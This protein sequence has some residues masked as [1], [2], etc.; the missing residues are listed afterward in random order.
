MV[1]MNNKDSLS[2]GVLNFVDFMTPPG[3]V[4]YPMVYNL[5]YTR[6]PTDETNAAWDAMFPSK[7]FDF[8]IS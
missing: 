1:Y 2:C 6:E 7:S 8:S 4:R 5:T 3:N